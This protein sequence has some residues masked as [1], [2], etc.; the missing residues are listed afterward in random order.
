MESLFPTLKRGA[1]QLCA[2]SAF[3]R[4]LLM[5]SSIKAT[6][7]FS[8]LRHPSAE[9]QVSDARPGAPGFEVMPF[10]GT[11]S[12]GLWNPRSQKRDL[13]HP[14][15]VICGRL[16]KLDTI[17]FRIGDPAKLSEVIAFAF[18]IDG[19]TFVYQTVQHTI[20]VVHLEIDHCFLCR[21]EVCIVL[22]EKAEDDVRVLRR[23]RKRE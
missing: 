5:Q 15:S 23:G 2:S 9:S 1:N 13:G 20:Q 21:R 16:P 11:L 6:I 3:V 18:W 10:Q 7:I 12:W 19:D 4:T 22:F 17:S 8:R 14:A